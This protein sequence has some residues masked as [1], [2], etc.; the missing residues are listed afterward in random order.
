LEDVLPSAVKKPSGTIAITGE[1]GS[2]KSTALAHLAALLGADGRVVFMDDPDARGVREV[3]GNH[4]VVFASLGGAA[5]IADQRFQMAPWGE[6]ERIEYLLAAHAEKCASVIGRLHASEDGPDLGGNP[7]LWRLV[8]D[9]MAA[10]ASLVD[11]REA[12]RRGLADLLADDSVANDAR[13]YCLACVTGRESQQLVNFWRLQSHRCEERLL[14][15]LGYPAVR[16]LLAAEEVVGQLRQGGAEEVLGCRRPREFVGEIARHAGPSD[17]A[18]KHLHRLVAI[19]QTDCQ[20]MAASILHAARLPWTPRRR[21][22][23]SG[24][25]LSGVSWSGRDLRRAN[26]RNTDLSEADLELAV[27][28]RADVS[29]ACLRGAVLRR[30]CLDHLVGERVDMTGADLSGATARLA[31]L[32]GASFRSAN[33]QQVILSGANLRD[34]DFTCARLRGARLEETGMENAVLDGADLSDAI[35]RE[36][37]LIGAS[38]HLGSPRSGLVDSP[39]A[40]EG[41]RTGFYADEF[42]QQ[43]YK[44]P[45]E[46]RKANLRGAD[47]RGAIVDGVD[48]YLVDL[49]EAKYTEPQLRHFRRCRAILA[50][51]A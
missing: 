32:P 30:A 6:D 49:R 7:E 35:L 48:F 31:R 33:L 29:R 34:A 46:I 40:S 12:L 17:L 14:R 23:L 11:A 39:L 41:T 15:L 22:R 2:G 51:P 3:A 13:R 4:L 26:L 9:Q 47:L 21:P 8:L 20:A 42:D 37:S 44:A 36:A 5:V 43:Y 1:R 24:A 25:Y 45:E 50:D 28:D 27:L 16:L 19:A 38:F 18:V 10:D